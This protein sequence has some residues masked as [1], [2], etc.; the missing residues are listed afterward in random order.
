MD[1]WDRHRQ[2]RDLS[3]QSGLK[4]PGYET[5]VQPET[6]TE[7]NG[8]MLPSCLSYS[9]I[10][11]DNTHLQPLGS[12]CTFPSTYA[13]V[14]EKSWGESLYSKETGSLIRPPTFFPPV[15]PDEFL[16]TDKQIRSVLRGFKCWSTLPDSDYAII[17]QIEK[18]H[19]VHHLNSVT[20]IPIHSCG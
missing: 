5:S 13:N 15:H 2:S 16:R 9:R 10:N 17:A 3:Q 20:S 12:F 1:V 6:A 8:N 11:A 19:Q 18:W 7:P 14:S 4:T